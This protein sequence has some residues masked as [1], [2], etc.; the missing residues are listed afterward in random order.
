MGVYILNS[1]GE[2]FTRAGVV[3]DRPLEAGWF[4]SQGVKASDQ[5]VTTGA[6]ALLS[7][8]LKATLKPD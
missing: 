6:Q 1:G 2:A 4:A 5:L 8:E 7:Q 3:L